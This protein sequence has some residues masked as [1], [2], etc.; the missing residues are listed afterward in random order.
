MTTYKRENFRFNLTTATLPAR[1]LRVI[2]NHL[3][4]AAREALA[5]RDVEELVGSVRIRMRPQHAGDEELRFGEAFPKHRHERNGA[6][7]AHEGNR[8]AEKRVR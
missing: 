7:L 8:L 1:A 5:G 6:A 4:H 3:G 2:G